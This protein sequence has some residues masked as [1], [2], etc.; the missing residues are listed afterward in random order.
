MYLGG[1]GR[2]GTTLLDRLLGE[3]PGAISLG[4]VVHLWE[5]GVV[6]GERCGCGA[7]F[8]D[9]PFWREAGQ[10]AFGG[11][12]RL[13]MERLRAL[14]A[15]V[16]RTRRIPVLARR[17]L[18]AAL[19]EQVDAYVS[20]YVRLYRAVAEVSGARVLID[21]SKQASLACCLRWA[22]AGSPD[23]AGPPG[24]PGS[25]GVDL[26]VLH[27]VR[28]SRGVAYSWTKKVRRP[29]A[30][31]GGEEFMAQWSPAKAA[32]YWNAE[33]GAFA[34]LARRGL[35]TMLV[36]YEEFLRTPI[37]SLRRIAEFAG[38]PTDDAALAFLSAGD[39][40]V[41]A[42]L[43]ANHTASG[44]PMRFRTGPIQ[45]RSDEEW[46]TR[47]AAAD[48]RRVTALTYPLLRRYGYLRGAPPPTN[49]PAAPPSSRGEAP[50]A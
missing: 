10:V 19:R 25:K 9:C 29:E 33:N 20:H 5:R 40:G 35:P 18:P 36:R 23:G 8:G 2:S 14:R 28:D 41:T 43:S 37:A 7:S 48:R 47:L 24:G 13:D 45:L 22:P 32:A 11:W 6:D 16:D 21:S 38:L 46:R 12:E 50:P 27:V 26:R 4:E 49:P 44:N 42:R 34:L 17:R 15:A 1:L 3:L 31:A 30:V 39:G